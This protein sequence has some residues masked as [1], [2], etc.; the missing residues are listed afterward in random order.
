VDRQVSIALAGQ[1]R[2]PEICAESRI[3]D[4]MA[5]IPYVGQTIFFTPVTFPPKPT[6]NKKVGFYANFFKIISTK[7]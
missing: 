2:S 5:A 1:S 7:Y 4:G 3:R 6:L